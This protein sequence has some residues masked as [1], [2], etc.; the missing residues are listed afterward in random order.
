MAHPVTEAIPVSGTAPAATVRQKLAAGAVW[1]VLTAGAV[2]GSDLT[3]LDVIEVSLNG[4]SFVYDAADT[5][6][7]H[8]GVTCLVSS[9]G[10]RFKAGGLDWGD[11]ICETR[12]LTA[13]PGSPTIGLKWLLPAAPT[14]AWAAYGKNIAQWT[15]AGWRFSAPS[16]GRKAYMKDE[17]R[18]LF[19]DATATWVEYPSRSL[20]YGTIPP[21]SL[22]DPFAII[23]V[24]D[25]RASPPGSMPGAGTAYIVAASPTGAFVGHVGE[26]ARS[27]GAA[28][29]FIVPGEGSTVYRKDLGVHYTYRSGAWGQT[30]APAGVQ[31]VKRMTASNENIGTIGGSL[32]Y[33]A[34]TAALQS[35]V[36]RALRFTLFE[37]RHAFGSGLAGDAYTIGLYKDAD[38]AATG[39]LATI[40]AA[41]SSAALALTAA[42]AATGRMQFIHTVADSL[43]HTWKIGVKRTAGAGS[44]S[45]TLYFDLLIEEIQV[46]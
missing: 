41:G 10:K 24:E 21:M 26:V 6:T 3:G 20:A 42:L 34:Q 29:E 37:F 7:A 33:S 19:Y 11:A 46:V 38:S 8:D 43:S 39:D 28:Y 27:N 15:A 16:Q 32:S 45:C 17:D 13:P 31:Q 5:T 12:G 22:S 35:A 14:G 18:H 2:S 25:A 44:R 30:V 9:D 4:Q 36:G 40:P 23:R 1:P